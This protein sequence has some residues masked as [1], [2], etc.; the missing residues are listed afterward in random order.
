MVTTIIQGYIFNI[1][2]FPLQNCMDC[3][4][5]ILFGDYSS[6]VFYPFSNKWG[7]LK[8]YTFKIFVFLKHS[9]KNYNFHIYISTWS[10]SAPCSRGFKWSWSDLGSSKAE[11]WLVDCSKSGFMSHCH[12]FQNGQERA[13]PSQKSRMEKGTVVC[14][15]ESERFPQNPAGSGGSDSPHGLGT[16]D[17][18]KNLLWSTSKSFI[19]LVIH[20]SLKKS[21]QYL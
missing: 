17:G 9:E 3:K 4:H 5:C 14:Q 1:W 16:E 18:R 11:P 20:N 7:I 2:K 8:A 6:T 19:K 21:M 13:Q 12:R 15:D 10:P